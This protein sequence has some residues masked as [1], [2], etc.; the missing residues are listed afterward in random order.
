LYEFLLIFNEALEKS[1]LKNF[2]T[3]AINFLVDKGIIGET[4]ECADRSVYGNPMREGGQNDGKNVTL[5]AE[6]QN[7]ITDIA[8]SLAKKAFCMHLIHGIR[9]S[10]R[11]EIYLPAM[12]NVL[13]SGDNIIY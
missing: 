13:E 5:T 1:E 4:F 6:Q 8:E 2:P 7:V 11:T 9:D 12:A 3:S 10:G